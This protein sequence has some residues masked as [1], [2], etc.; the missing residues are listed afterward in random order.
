MVLRWIPGRGE[1]E[2][3][4]VRMVAANMAI[5]LED[6]LISVT[7]TSSLRGALAID[8][9]TKIGIRRLEVGP[10]V[11]GRGGDAE[12]ARPLVAAAAEPH[13]SVLDRL[14]HPPATFLFD[15]VAG[16]SGAPAPVDRPEDSR[17]G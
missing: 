2:K 13:C 16:P 3:L 10:L 5:E 15:H 6:V 9:V 12:W 11:V 17:H 4:T 1:T 7:G 8:G 14:R